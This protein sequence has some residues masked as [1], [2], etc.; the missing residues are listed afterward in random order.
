MLAIAVS[1]SF[2]VASPLI[3]AVMSVF[4][5]SDVASP[6]VAS[7]ILS[8]TSFSERPGLASM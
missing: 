2:A 6:L 8:A 5:P 3:A 4:T 7:V 1:I